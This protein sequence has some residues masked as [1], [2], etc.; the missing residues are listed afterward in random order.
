M[1]DKRH[2]GMPGRALFGMVIIA[3]G[4]VFFLDRREIVEAWTILQF[5]P[6]AF[7]LVG[8]TR[9]IG[10]GTS[11]ERLGS[12]FWF[13]AGMLLLGFTLNLVPF[14]FEDIFPLLLI[15]L[16]AWVFYRSFAGPRVRSGGTDSGA[17]LNPFAFMAG[18]HRKNSSPDF[19]GGSATA[20]MGGIEIDL[21]D[22]KIAGEEAVLDLFAFWGGIDVFV[23]GDWLVDNRVTP[24]LGGVEDQRKTV[25]TDPTKRLVLKGS[26]IMGGVEIQN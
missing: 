24:V 1:S 9:L 2:G 11:G 18:L 13:A 21:R 25:G 4:A 10:G 3:L 19:R 5:W 8:L 20:V 15:L 7:L 16:G 23:P 22:A 17:T 26:A 12:L 14:D 6:V